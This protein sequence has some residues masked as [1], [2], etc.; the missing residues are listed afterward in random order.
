MKMDSNCCNCP[1]AMPRKEW[2]MVSLLLLEKNGTSATIWAKR[3]LL[4]RAS[5]AMS[6]W[7]FSRENC[8]PKAL[9]ACFNSCM[10]KSPELSKSQRLA[11]KWGS[12]SFIFSSEL[13]FDSCSSQL[14]DFVMVQQNQGQS[15]ERSS[16]SSTGASS[17]SFQLGT[18]GTFT[19][20]TASPTPAS[21]WLHWS[22]VGF[23]WG[24]AKRRS[25]SVGR[26]GWD[27]LLHVQPMAVPTL[28]AGTTLGC[29]P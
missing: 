28:V 17:A 8:K 2:G 10:S 25:S 29:R 9:A 18:L 13:I 5:P 6:C 19:T 12:F 11:T 21:P 27:A 20:F 24:E 22:C 4:I 15:T 26:L 14:S 1:S 7:S 16:P 23:A 3:S